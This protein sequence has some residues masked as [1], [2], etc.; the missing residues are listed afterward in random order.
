LFKG[1][2]TD[3]RRIGVYVAV[4]LTTPSGQP[5][6][7]VHPDISDVTRLPIS[8]EW[9]GKISVVWSV[10]PV[11]KSAHDIGYEYEGT[12]FHLHGTENGCAAF[13]ATGSPLG[14]P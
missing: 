6:G 4:S 13:M 7:V 11:D 2:C 9:G 10:G 1:H 12:T 8:P 3:G 14:D 5:C